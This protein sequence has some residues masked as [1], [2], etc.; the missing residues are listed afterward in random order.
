MSK[1]V[2]DSNSIQ[3][4]VTATGAS[5]CSINFS[6]NTFTF[7]GTS[8][9]TRAILTNVAEPT[10]GSDVVTKSFLDTKLAEVNQNIQWKNA[11]RA[12]TT[13]N[14]DG[15]YSGNQTITASTNGA[16]PAQDGVTMN[17]GD[18]ILVASQ[19]DAK[20]NGIY[21]ITNVG[22]ATNRYQLDRDSDAD[23]VEELTGATATV[24]EGTLNSSAVYL[25]ASVITDIADNKNF[26]Q[27]SN[28]ISDIATDD[29]LRKEGRTIKV[30]TSGAV[31]IVADAV[32]VVS[33]GITNTEL[34]PNAVEQ[35]SIKDA[36]ISTEKV[37]DLAITNSLLAGQIEGSKLRDNTLTSN[38]YG[39]QSITSQAYA[40][41]SIQSNA[42]GL[43][44]VDQSN[45]ATGACG[46]D[47]I[48]NGAVDGSIHI[49]AGSL[50][51]ENFASN[52]VGEDALKPSS[53]GSAQ[54]KSGAILTS[55]VGNSQITTAKLD[56]TANSEAVDTSVVRNNAITKDKIAPSSIDEE[57][58]IDGSVTN[59][60]LA[61]SSITANK[62]ST[63]SQ[64]N[65]SGTITANA[66]QLGG[67]ASSGGTYSLAKC[68]HNHIDVVGNYHFGNGA[69]KRICDNKV[70]FSYEQA[71][72]C[73]QSIGRLIYKSQTGASSQLQ[74][75]IGV[76]FW[77]NPTTKSAFST[78][79][80]FD[81][82]RNTKGDTDEHEALL[83]A[84][85]SDKSAG[86]KR[87]SEVQFWARETNTGIIIEA[88]QDLIIQHLVVADDSN[89]QNE[90][91]DGSTLSPV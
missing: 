86:K 20:Q 5:K 24:L 23:S 6:D 49:S 64:L 79:V 83:Q 58:L 90:A 78:P 85:A 7:S 50:I 12:K 59:A 55:K 8:G 72:I 13:G 39:T 18:R 54:L 16:L 47:Q 67:G 46:A 75:V 38:L 17:T 15:T 69:F 33:N 89:V 43:A 21:K 60:K 57:R 71:V 44:E 32:T 26:V 34:A 77:E 80:A 76:R 70:E 27:T 9:S 84:F 91:W 28:A 25:Q 10:N 4:Q 14:I 53:V 82:F 66:I 36:S 1:T 11:V 41:R 40:L 3:N 19:T 56:S 74:M 62:L 37:Q 29:G 52:S 63:L 73:V 65:V 42:I 87:I 48:E 30:S 81:S 22:D 45:L 2:I 35:D 61:D 68:I 88:G 51:T 31:G